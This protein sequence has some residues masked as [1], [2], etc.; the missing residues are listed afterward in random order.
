[1]SRLLVI[2]LAAFAVSGCASERKHELLAANLAAAPPAGVEARHDIFVA[3]TRKK[4]DDFRI[5]FDRQRSDTLGFA[6]V[7]VTVPKGH[8]IGR[9]ERA[10]GGKPGKPAKEFAAVDLKIYESGQAFAT[11][12]SRRGD[13]VLVFVHGYNT[14]FDDGVYRIT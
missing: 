6:R 11:D 8:E 5:V 1:R 2:V 4:A 13:R 10:K 9:I 7:G 3:T 12:I 14:G